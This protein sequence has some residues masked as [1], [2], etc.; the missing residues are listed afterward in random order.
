MVGRKWVDCLTGK[1][2]DGWQEM[3]R[4][5]DRKVEGRIAG[6]WWTV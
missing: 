5:F 4:L 3:G 1:W 6:K 2:K